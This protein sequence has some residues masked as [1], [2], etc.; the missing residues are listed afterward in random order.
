MLMNLRIRILTAFIAGVLS[1][2]SLFGQSLSL[3]QTPNLSKCTGDTLRLD[4]GIT[5]NALAATNRLRVLIA[6][7]MPSS[8]TV[9]NADTLPITE[10]Q[11]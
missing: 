10:F 11:S 1:T 3:V 2:P 9:A 8:F 6:P 4:L 5:G 7:G